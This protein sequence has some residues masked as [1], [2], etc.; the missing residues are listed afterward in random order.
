MSLVQGTFTWTENMQG[1]VL[2]AFFYGY[3]TTQIPGGMLAEKFGGKRLL[4]FG[5]FWTAFL[6][7]LTPP[8]TR[9]G[10]FAAIV[11]V[12]IL[13]GIGE[14]KLSD[15]FD[16]CN[17]VNIKVIMITCFHNWCKILQIS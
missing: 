5:I 16:K 1:V 2:A 4:L 7:I 12:R 9:A 11:A 8:I 13:E 10:G 6:T 3:V 14:V 17:F 15:Y